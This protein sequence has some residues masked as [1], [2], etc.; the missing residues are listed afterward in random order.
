MIIHL[1]YF[2]NQMKKQFNQ[3]LSGSQHWLIHNASCDILLDNTGIWRRGFKE[4]AI[5][6]TALLLC[7]TLFAQCLVF[8]FLIW[9]LYS[10]LLYCDLKIKW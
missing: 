2:R 8:R 7:G 9:I 5:E 10:H 4:K 3:M 6:E 1:I